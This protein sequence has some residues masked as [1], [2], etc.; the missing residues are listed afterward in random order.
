MRAG[1]VRDV[2]KDVVGPEDTDSDEAVTRLV[3]CDCSVASPGVL[4]LC[5]PAMVTY[6]YR[7]CTSAGGCSGA[8]LQGSLSQGAW[9]R[10]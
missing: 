4:W 5:D 8:R 10:W 7:S 1:Q 3:S 6:A 9:S 2:F